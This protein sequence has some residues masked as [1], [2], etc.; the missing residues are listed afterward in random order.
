MDN[1]PFITEIDGDV[2][3]EPENYDERFLS[4][5]MVFELYA[6]PEM[7]TGDVA[8]MVGV[9]ESDIVNAVFY[10]TEEPGVYEDLIEDSNLGPDAEIFANENDLMEEPSSDEVEDIWERCRVESEEYGAE[11]VEYSGP[12]GQ[13]QDMVE[14]QV[15]QR[16]FEIRYAPDEDQQYRSA[17]EMHVLTGPE[18][19]EEMYFGAD[20]EVFFIGSTVSGVEKEFE[21]PEDAQEIIKHELNSLVF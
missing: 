4:L 14:E 11:H 9:D 5:E 13:L 2:Y 8:R 18:A 10:W 7:D 17:I 15:D 6:D 19:E 16:D 1:Y 20:G 3:L 12:V 21:D